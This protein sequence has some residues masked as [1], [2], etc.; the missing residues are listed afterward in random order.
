M[1]EAA[2][3]GVPLV[4]I[5]LFGDQF[6]NA[7][8]VVSKKIGVFVDIAEVARDEKVVVD[9][10]REVLINEMWVWGGIGGARGTHGDCV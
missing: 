5:P 6:Y 2:T 4:G 8:L 1:T 3:A 9:A 7:A 10:L